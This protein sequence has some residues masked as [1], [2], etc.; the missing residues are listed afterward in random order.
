MSLHSVRR[1]LLQNMLAILRKRDSPSAHNMLVR[2]SPV[3]VCADS[4]IVT[5]ACQCEAHCSIRRLVVIVRKDRGKVGDFE[6]L[7]CLLTCPLELSGVI[8]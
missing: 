5:V 7:S 1:C 6:K 4:P 8:D 2:N 3:K